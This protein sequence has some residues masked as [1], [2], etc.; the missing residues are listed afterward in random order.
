MTTHYNINTADNFDPEALI[1]EVIDSG[2]DPSLFSDIKDNEIPRAKNIFEWLTGKEFCAIPSVF[3]KQIEVLANFLGDYCDK[4]S[5]LDYMVLIPVDAAVID[6]QDRVV[7]LEHG[8]CPKCGRTRLDQQHDPDAPY[9][10]YIELNGCCGMR[11]GKTVTTAMLSTYMLH[12][13][14]MIPDPAALF[15]LL[16][17]Q[18]LYGVFVAATAG[19]AQ[20]T[21]WQLFRDRFDTAPW[22]KNYHRFLK[23]EQERIGEEFFRVR[24]TYLWYGHKGLSLTYQGSDIRTI[25]G[26]TRWFCAIDEIGWF[27]EVKDSGKIK[28][29][30]DETH[31][32]LEKAVRT[33]RS[34]AS[35][36]MKQGVVDVPSAFTA[37]ISSPSSIKDKIM[38]LVRESE[39]DPKKY[40][41]HYATW[42]FNP[43]ET[44]EELW[45]EEGGNRE[46]FYRDY[47]AIPPLANQQFIGAS[48]LVQQSTSGE[49][50][51]FSVIHGVD[52][53]D[54]NYQYVYAKLGS[55]IG[56]KQCPRLLSIDTGE[57]FNSFSLCVSRLDKNDRYIVEAVVEISPRWDGKTMSVNFNWVFEKLILPLTQAFR[58]EFVAFDR[59]NSTD[60]MHRLRGEGTD[61]DQISLIWPDFIDFRARL[62]DHKIII[63][64]MEKPFSSIESNYS[65]AIKNS[66]VT[67]LVLQMLTVREVGR[68]VAKPIDGED[69][70]WRSMVLGHRVMR[71]EKYHDRFVY[72]GGL[73]RRVGSKSVGSFLSRSGGYFGNVGNGQGTSGLV[74]RR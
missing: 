1:S 42:E 73:G 49:E 70:L 38:R 43:Y 35:A 19:Q 17:G 46:T 60:L 30:A 53:D 15:S 29:N 25:R 40:A 8:I 2:Y 64:K 63:P 18:H 54:L 21:L 13:F 36:L 11:A 51:L 16:P 67:H 68:K 65:E 31:Q 69:D 71:D 45:S 44:Y 22:F 66:P 47:G 57:K 26:R 56:D 37:N 3:P 12:R 23:G 4:C 9:S 48:E 72:S 6:I 24:D 34:R 58:I 74:K 52:K 20:E 50:Q 55:F 39:N 7:W 5:D 14:L 28:Y 32:A 10:G 41:F 61:S 27:D 62:F 59:W 33:L